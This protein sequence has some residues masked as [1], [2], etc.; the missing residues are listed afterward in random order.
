[1]SSSDAPAAHPQQQ[2][3]H[4]NQTEPPSSNSPSQSETSNQPPNSA[5]A[6]NAAAQVSFRRQRASRACEVR[7]VF[8]ILSPP[9][10]ARACLSRGIYLTGNSHPLSSTSSQ[11]RDPR[12][13]PWP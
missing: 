9:L 7:G 4:Q 12:R 6:I 3:Q 2:Q 8:R 13:W 11:K 5:A 10:V 1:M